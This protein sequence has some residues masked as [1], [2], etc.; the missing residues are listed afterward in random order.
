MTYEHI[1]FMKRPKNKQT[2]PKKPTL[3]SNMMVS[4][5]Y[6]GVEGM[7]PVKHVMK[8]EKYLEQ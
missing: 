8:L 7:C 3:I 6:S 5:S 4:N 2:K 1:N